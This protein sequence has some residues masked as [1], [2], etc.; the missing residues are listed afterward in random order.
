MLTTAEIAQLRRI[1]EPGWSSATAWKGRFLPERPSTNQCAVTAML[2]Q[3]MLGGDLVET[4]V[5]GVLH[6]FNRLPDGQ[7]I[8]LTR[9]QFP[10]DAVAAG[11][12][13]RT[14]GSLVRAGDV[15]RR[16]LL[17]KAAVGKRLAR[18]CAA[19]GANDRGLA[20]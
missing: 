3:D 15:Q 11:E 9:D 12:R 7:D 18:H 4:H 20:A 19:R 1:I 16:Y 5:N 2:V 14:R 6:F 17:L 10:A 13:L 8:D